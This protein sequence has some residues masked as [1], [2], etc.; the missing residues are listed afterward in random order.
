MSLRRKIL[1]LGIAVSSLLA[2]ELLLGGLGLGLPYRAIV[3][4]VGMAAIGWAARR[5]VNRL[6][7]DLDA[8][9][10]AID[11]TARGQFESPITDAHTDETAELAEAVR[12]LRER[13]AE[14]GRRLVEALRIESLNVL[15]SIL[16]HDMKNL[17][18]RLH[19][20]S[21]NLAANYDDPAF[22]DSL[23]RT[24]DDTTEKMD[25]MV[26]RFREEKQIVIVKIRVNL[27]D[28]VHSAVG[29][30]RRD[31]AE[32]R[33]TEQY[34]E[35]PLIWA[36]TLLVENAIFNIAENA[37]DAM[38][39]G[40][41]LVVRTQLVENAGNSHRKVVI[42]IADTG[43]G[44]S[45][46]FIRNELFAPFVTTKPRGLGLGLYT[47]R[48]IIEMHDGEVHVRSEPGRGTVFS[49]YLPITD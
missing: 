47:C 23:V 45:E 10:N 8:I 25:Q 26:R 31:A 42:D 24:L 16:V 3:T 39:G 20:L 7:V 44:M 30:L 34:G 18:F 46:A 5:E 14:M 9:R 48:Q 49:V 32:I 13:L 1:L 2:V 41:R 36:D 17:S 21:Q 28:I 43:L 6:L 38:P 12:V 4:L 22:R 29:N 27:N 19:A 35:L 33:V 37:C 11:D 15:G 40:G